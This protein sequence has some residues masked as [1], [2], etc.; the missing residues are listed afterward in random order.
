MKYIIKDDLD[1]TQAVL[2][3]DDYKITFD[4]DKGETGK[5]PY[6]RNSY[7]KLREVLEM[8]GRTEGEAALNR[9]I[10]QALVNLQKQMKTAIR[11]N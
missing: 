1:L 5:K 3:G 4:K 7:Y 9:D 8:N 2:S 11:L 10:N 6:E